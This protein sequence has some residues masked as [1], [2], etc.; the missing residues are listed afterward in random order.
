MSKEENWP[1][2]KSDLVTIGNPNSSKGICTLWTQK[3]KILQHIDNNNFIVAGQC[4]SHQD[5]INLIL[6]Q[7]LANKKIHYIIICGTDITGTGETLIAL[8]ENGINQERKI[9][10]PHESI[11]E[12]EI[13]LDAIERFRTNVQ[14]IDKRDNKDWESFNDFLISLE[15]REPWGDPE[16]Y[17]RK[18]PEPPK[19]S[20]SERTGFIIRNE[21]IGDAWLDI[22]DTI[23][24]FGHVKR[25]QYGEDQQEIVA[26]TTIITN[27]DSE[28][29]DW[30]H[31]FKFSREHLEEYILTLTTAEI[32]LG[33]NYSYG[34]RLREHFGVD[35]IDSMIKQLKGAI[36]SRRAV[37]VTWN[38][39]KDHDNAHS[40]CLD[41][42]Q[43][44]VQDKLTLTAYFRS[45]D[46]FE[47]WPKNAFALR[48]VQYEIAN[49]LNVP[50]GDLIII[51]NSAHIYERD[52]ARS[53]EVIET[54]L[55]HEFKLDP[56]GNLLIS[57][58]DDKIKLTHL[59][60]E[61]IQIGQY[62]AKSAKEA[63]RL[64]KKNQVISQTDHAFDVGGELAKAEI[65]L[66]DPSKEYI[67]DKELKDKNQNQNIEYQNTNYRS[68]DYQNHGYQNTRYQ[69]P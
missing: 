58:E 24:K 26:L 7:V 4:Y 31:F 32:P 42:I 49:A 37:G 57:I 11:I 48:A 52:W 10:G 62:N 46:M 29:V 12:P 28:N 22:L 66:K 15:D 5:G 55:K 35:Q 16:V 34:N 2:Y 47:A 1:T 21:K 60:P 6:R 3:D 36:F 64:L 54:N 23:L 56:R 20:P 39:P 63:Y 67:Q 68:T 53:E 59:S 69:D 44:L 45:N 50:V 43:A 14:I 30:K 38:V 8:K 19:S 33:L 65:A 18:I 51:S 40:P 41:L 25:S 61:G 13:P 9:I 17:E 27:E